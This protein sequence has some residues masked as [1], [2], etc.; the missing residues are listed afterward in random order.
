MHEIIAFYWLDL[1]VVSIRLVFLGGVKV[2]LGSLRD[3][4]GPPWPSFSSG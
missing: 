3:P 2:G 1:N 4:P